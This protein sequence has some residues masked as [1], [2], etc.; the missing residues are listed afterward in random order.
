[1]CHHCRR[2]ALHFIDEI[3][4]CEGIVRIKVWLFLGMLIFPSHFSF[5]EFYCK[6]CAFVL[7]AHFP[8]PILLFVLTN[9]C[10]CT[11]FRAEEVL[12]NNLG[13]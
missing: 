10:F 12:N 8:L 3:L 2:I 6:G 7:S 1:M 5:C 13:Q 9:V 4:A 11:A